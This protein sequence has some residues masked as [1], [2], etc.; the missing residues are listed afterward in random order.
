MAL[1]FCSNL[2]LRRHICVYIC[3]SVDVKYFFLVFLWCNWFGLKKSRNSQHTFFFVPCFI[4]SIFVEVDQ[5]KKKQREQTA[6]CT[7][8][9]TRCAYRQYFNILQ[10]AQTFDFIYYYITVISAANTLTYVLSLVAIT[11]YTQLIRVWCKL[12]SLFCCVVKSEQIVRLVDSFHYECCAK[13]VWTV[14]TIKVKNNNKLNNKQNKQQQQT[15]EQVNE[16]T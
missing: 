14:E 2:F 9:M 6:D 10:A 8:A 5:K 3:L 4:S 7:D 16:R 1:L 11:V 15:N 13:K 12:L